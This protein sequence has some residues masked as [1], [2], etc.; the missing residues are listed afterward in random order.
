MIKNDVIHLIDFGI[1]ISVIPGEDTNT[2][3]YRDTIIGSPKYISFYIHQGY[4]PM[5][6]DDLISAGYCFFYFIENEL[7]WSILPLVRTPE[8]GTSSSVL[9]NNSENPVHNIYLETHILH[10]KNQFRKKKKQWTSIE[11]IFYNLIEKWGHDEN[12][13]Y[14]QLFTNVFEYFGLCYNLQLNEMPYYDEL[15]KVLQKSL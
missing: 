4:E 9:T 5:Y 12:P 7:P 8:F 13:Q 11:R 1:A 3:A 2:D 6:R 15:Y 14:T 10:E